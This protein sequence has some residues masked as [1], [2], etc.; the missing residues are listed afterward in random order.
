ML[1]SDIVN[2]FIKKYNYKTYLEIGYGN[3]DT[4]HK[5]ELPVEDKIGVDGGGGTPQ[6]DAYVTRMTSDKFFELNKKFTNKKFDII[7]IDGSHL[8]EDVENDMSNSLE[9]LNE[10][11]TIVMHD[12]NPESVHWQE[13]SQ[14]PLVPGWNGDTWKAFVK[15]RSTRKDLEMFVVDSDFGCGVL[16]YGSQKPLN[17]DLPKSLIYEAFEPNKKEWLNLISI[18]EFKTKVEV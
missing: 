4:F 10:G 14:S 8:W 3:G 18:E 13:R 15:F 9:C 7:F 17:L 5:I 16:R 11:G 2:S 12:C 6:G 1:R